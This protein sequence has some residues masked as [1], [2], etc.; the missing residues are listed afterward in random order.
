[1][2][3]VVHAKWLEQLRVVAQR[4]EALREERSKSSEDEDGRGEAG[5]PE[6][7]RKAPD[8]DIVADSKEL[9]VMVEN[10]LLVV[11][12]GLVWYCCC[13]HASLDAGLSELFLWRFRPCSSRGRLRGPGTGQTRNLLLE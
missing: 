11:L 2:A 4:E 13:S 7:A 9:E 5:A 3:D 1:M 12:V 10:I 8:E 6:D